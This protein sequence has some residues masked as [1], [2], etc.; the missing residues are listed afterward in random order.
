MDRSVGRAISRI[1][2]QRQTWWMVRR[3]SDPKGV[4]HVTCDIGRGGWDWRVRIGS[5]KRFAL[6]RVTANRESVTDKGN[7]I[8]V[9][10]KVDK[11]RGAMVVRGEV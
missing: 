9:R 7:L 4:W 3:D 5:N 8:E 10:R 11:M 2:A 1:D 6:R